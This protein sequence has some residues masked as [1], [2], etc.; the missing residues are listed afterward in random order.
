[1]GFGPRKPKDLGPVAPALCPNCG[2]HVTFRLL[3]MRNW[4]SLFFVP[5]VPGR[6]R[7]VV[8]CPICQYG[9][10]L[11]DEAVPGARHL[12]E[13]TARDHAHSDPAGYRK[14]VDEFWARLGGQRLAD[15]QDAQPTGATDAASGLD[16]P[17]PEPGSATTSPPAGWYDDPFGQSEQRY[18][19]GHQWTAGT[20][21]PVF[22][23]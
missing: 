4:F 9:I 6:A 5:L 13:L 18:W 10:E 19:D 8:L 14:A 21:P 7:H 20:N 16:A 3:E 22:R 1:M 12:V 11:D 17:P 15:T 2:N 23:S